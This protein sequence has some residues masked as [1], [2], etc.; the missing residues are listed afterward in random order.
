MHICEK[1]GE[2]T[3]VSCPAESLERGG[4]ESKIAESVDDHE[5]DIGTVKQTEVSEELAVN[6]K[7]VH[8]GE[9]SGSS[10]TVEALAVFNPELKL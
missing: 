2:N 1:Q 7:T 6:E 4:D 8:L 9:N 3:S 5:R 10:N